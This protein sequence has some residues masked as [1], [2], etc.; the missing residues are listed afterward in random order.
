MG[1]IRGATNSRTIKRMMFT[2]KENKIAKV[3]NACHGLLSQNA[4]LIIYLR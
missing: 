2:V 3:L 1:M 4:L